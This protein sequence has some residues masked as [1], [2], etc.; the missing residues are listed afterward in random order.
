MTPP[1]FTALFERLRGLPYGL[2]VVDQREHALQCAGHALAAGADD[3]VV[4][5]AALHD[6]GYLFP[7]A[8]VPHEVSGA[9]FVAALAGARTASLVR[10]HVDAK[11]YLVGE[12]PSYSL[13]LASQVS[14]ERQGGP[15]PAGEREAFR[16]GPHFA[17]LIALR[18]WDDGAK[19]PGRA[20]PPVEEVVACYLRVRARLEATRA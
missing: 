7:A 17:D 11:R 15:M 6:A 10:G 16:A 2:E 8:G 1:E 12:D 9:R 20:A 3:E 4:L 14:L 5:A 18:R 19:E 13:S